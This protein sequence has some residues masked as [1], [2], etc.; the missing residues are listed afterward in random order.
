MTRPRSQQAI[1]NYRYYDP[2]KDLYHESLVDHPAHFYS[3]AQRKTALM[4]IDMQYL[5]AAK[6]YG[7]FKDA[8]S[9]GVPEKAQQYYFNRLEETVVPNIKRLLHMFRK[10]RL[11]VIHTRIQCL[12]Q[13]GRDRGAGHKRLG[14]MATPGSKEAEFLEE[15]AP[16]GDEIILNKTASG[17]FSS[18]NLHYVL[19]N[20]E[21]QALVL[22][23]VYTNE[24]VETTARNAC[25]LGYLVS[26]VDDA[27]ATVTPDLHQGALSV[28]KDRYARVVKT[29]EVVADISSFYAPKRRKM[30]AKRSRK[31]RNEIKEITPE[32]SPE[33]TP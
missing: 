17:V 20:L 25:D 33:Y 31:L 4:V 13:D 14:L 3:L 32:I 12:T 11:E 30:K 10:Y 1:K 27:C 6:G 28:L 21:I 23:G 5:D 16:E 19:N 22:C 15:V 9:S 8:L 2:L 24:C 29:D 18:T 7:V 26:L